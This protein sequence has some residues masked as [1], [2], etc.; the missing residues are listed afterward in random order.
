VTLTVWS[1][2]ESGSPAVSGQHRPREGF[3]DRHLVRTV[4]RGA[5]VRLLTT[6]HTNSTEAGAVEVLIATGVEVRISC[7]TSYTTPAEMGAL[8][9]HRNHPTIVATTY[10]HQ[11]SSRP[12]RFAHTPRTTHRPEP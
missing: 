3:A 11:R 5:R 6:T 8:Y 1:E 4:A 2:P 7:G 12:E 9:L 10:R